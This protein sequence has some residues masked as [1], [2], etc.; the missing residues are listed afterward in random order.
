MREPSI[1]LSLL[2]FGLGPIAV[3]NLGA[4]VEPEIDKNSIS[5]HRVRR[6]NMPIRLMPTSEIVSLTPPEVL[7]TVPSG[8][9]PAPQVGQQAS[10]QVRAPEVMIGTVVD[11]DRATLLDSWKLTIRLKEPFPAGTT[12][13]TK[14][15]SLVEVGELK[16]VVYFERPASARPNTEMILFVLEPNGDFARRVTVRLGSQ[17][18]GLIQI[19]R[20][21][22]P[23]DSVIVTDTANWNSH[24]RLRIK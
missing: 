20:G 2:V 3:Q 10:V 12:V 15:G 18:G 5:V 19:V 8:T 6:G 16:D 23:G 11:I 24:E 13:G 4:Q 21:L 7:A 22:S 17:S 1:L 9:V 14:V